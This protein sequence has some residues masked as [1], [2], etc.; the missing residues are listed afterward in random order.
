MLAGAFLLFACAANMLAQQLIQGDANLLHRAP[1]RY[2]AEA[3]RNKVQ[4]IVVIEA[5]LNERGIVTDAHVISGPD[6]LR[7]AALLSILDWH[8]AP[9]T[10]SPAH[11]TVEFK[12]PEPKPVLLNGAPTVV[13]VSQKF[14]PGP[15]PKLDVGIIKRIQFVDVSPL[16]R[17]TLLDRLPFKEG[18]SVQSD[19]LPRVLDVLR[20]VDEHLSA[21]YQLLDFDGERRQFGLRISYVSR[22]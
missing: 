1:I 13:P 4:G 15:P 3:L 18:D 5:S 20:T 8:Y 16:V 17:D 7:K 19:T 22:D 2:P 6:Q 21:S 11:V 9:G 12:T 14:D 10:L